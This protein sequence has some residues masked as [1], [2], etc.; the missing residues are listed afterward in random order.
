MSV[1]GWPDGEARPMPYGAVLYEHHGL[2]NGLINIGALE[3]GA[4]PSLAV[5]AHNPSGPM[6]FV[7]DY[8]FIGATMT[9]VPSKGV[10]HPGDASTVLIANQANSISGISAAWGT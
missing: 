9:F 3:C 2:F 6:V 8:K 4:W 7:V 10:P 5:S 1:H